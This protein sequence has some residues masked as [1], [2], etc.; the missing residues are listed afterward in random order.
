M[1]LPDGRTELAPGLAD[2][3]QILLVDLG[4]GEAQVVEQAF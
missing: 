1:G 2:R 4:P 3:E